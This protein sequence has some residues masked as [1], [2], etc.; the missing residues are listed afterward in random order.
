MD[1]VWTIRCL[2]VCKGLQR[3]EVFEN[4]ENKEGWFFGEEGGGK[5]ARALCGKRQIPQRARVLL[6]ASCDSLPY[7]EIMLNLPHLSL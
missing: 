7:V 2:H 4:N 6:A 3:I 1:L 5:A